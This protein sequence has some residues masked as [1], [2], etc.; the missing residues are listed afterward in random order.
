MCGRFHRFDDVQK[1]A[2]QFRAKY[3]ESIF[4]PPTFNA[5]P[6][7]WQ[8]VIRLD[9]DGER[10]IVNMRWRFVHQ[11]KK[12]YALGTFLNLPKMREIE[13]STWL[14]L[15]LKRRSIQISLSST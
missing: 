9:R 2:T 3:D 15:G 8:P 1:M 11:G 7:S 5:P 4:A 14:S 13:V 6:Q 10:E 12:N